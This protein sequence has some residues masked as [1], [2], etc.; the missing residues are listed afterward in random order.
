MTP[1]TYQP[2]VRSTEF[3]AQHVTV[4][5]GQQPTSASQQGVVQQATQVTGYVRSLDAIPHN[6]VT[7]F[8]TLHPQPQ[9]QQVPLAR[10]F[11]SGARGA[12]GT[13]VYIPPAQTAPS[14]VQS[15]Q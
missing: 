3:V 13:W 2:S 4:V 12:T 8:R 15:A 14:A 1:V 6:A 7:Y 5:Q 10:N 11:G 9:A